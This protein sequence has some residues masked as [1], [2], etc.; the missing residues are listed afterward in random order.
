MN[1]ETA[2]DAAKIL[3]KGGCRSVHIG[4]GEPFLN[5]EGLL[6]VIGE[7]NK[8]GIRIEYIETNAFW[9]SEPAAAERLRRLAGEGI[10][11]LCISVDPYHAEYVPY[12]L[13]LLLG[14]ACEREGMGYFLWKREFLP[15]LSELDAAKTHSRAEFEAVLSKAYIDRAAR[16]YGISYG[17]RA[18][19]IEDEFG[20][21]QPPETLEADA[22]PCKNLLS[23]GHFH[24][25][26][27]GFFIPPGCTG[28]KL[29]LAEAA[30]GI[31][32]GKYP[33]FEALYRNGAAGLAALARE[34]G[35]KPRAEGYAGKCGLCFYARAFLA[36]KGGCPE[37]DL[38]HY[39]EAMKYYSD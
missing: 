20:P 33:A 27:E 39:E 11:A 28:I 15:A 36:G 3:R 30:F 18:V 6:V 7:L 34:R 8:A 21:R 16:L 10:D 12:G 32:E 25:D 5:F 17:G 29:P 9:A 31:P 35:F 1:R 14:E 4:G 26:L 38:R 19:N 23:T 24:V 2:A 37:L 13:P 22:S